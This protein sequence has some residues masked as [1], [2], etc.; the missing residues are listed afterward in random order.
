MTAVHEIIQRCQ[1]HGVWLSINGDKLH[2]V[3]ATKLTPELKAVLLQYKPD[4]LA[5][6]AHEDAAEYVAERTAICAADGLPPTH[7]R[8]VFQYFLT[9]DP[10]QPLIML[11]T[12]GET[13]EQATESLRDRFGA[14]KVLDV[15][16]YEW[17]P[18]PPCGRLQ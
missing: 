1:Q 15:R 4:I 9:A 14:A 2:V 18:R 12:P 11:G 17:P 5:A 10:G 6:L 3:P 7:L 8:P 16:L 13:L